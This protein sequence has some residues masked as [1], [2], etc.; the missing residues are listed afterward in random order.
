MSEEKKASSDRSYFKELYEIPDYQYS[1]SDSQPSEDIEDVLRSFG[2]QARNIQQAETS[3]PEEAPQAPPQAP[4]LQHTVEKIWDEEPTPPPPAEESFGELL[5][6]DGNDEASM[7]D[8]Y[9]V[10]GNEVR[11]ENRFDSIEQRFDFD[12][13]KE[14]EKEKRQKRRL[15]EKQRKARR[16]LANA[17]LQGGFEYT[18]KSQAKQLRSQ[19]R[20]YVFE[21]RLRTWVMT[22]LSLLSLYLSLS[23][24]FNLPIPVRL[25]AVHNPTLWL[26]ASTVLLA[27]AGIL[28]AHTLCGGAV[29]LVRLSGNTDA[30]CLSAFLAAAVEHIALFW[31]TDLIVQGR[32]FLFTPLVLLILTADSIAAHRAMLR[33]RLSFLVATPPTEPLYAL[34]PV[35]DEHTIAQ[36]TDEEFAEEALLCAACQTEHP[37]KFFSHSS[38]SGRDQA[39]N[40]IQVPASVLL[41]VAATVIYG[42]VKKDW[43][44]ALSCWCVLSIA[45][46]PLAIFFAAELPLFRAVKSLFRRGSTLLGHHAYENL[47]DMGAVVLRDDELLGRNGVMIS[48]LKVLGN[49]LLN[50]VMTDILSLF[51]ASGGAIFHAFEAAIKGAES[52]LRP[53]EK[54]IFYPEKGIAGAV[55]GREIFIGSPNSAVKTASACPS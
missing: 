43:L 11:R 51:N 42:F 20:E 23:P 16:E 8:I 18:E 19:L 53:V 27:A 47:A 34:L 50:E 44:G 2:R 12:T 40:N 28:C 14:I 4:Q 36:L 55:G 13:E 45:C 22:F 3:V 25:S 38:A 9:A 46:C 17:G 21:A 54:F 1:T 52:E 31:H 5:T 33:E 39:V 26:L 10:L 32:M 24:V 30:L 48:G 15:K 49:H 35:R 37:E 7:D 6:A 29:S 41:T